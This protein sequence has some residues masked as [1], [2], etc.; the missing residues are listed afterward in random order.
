MKITAFF[1][2]AMLGYGCAAKKMAVSNADTLISYQVTKR[3]PLYTAQK[4]ELGADIDQ[5]LN[6]SKPMAKEIV[7]VI[8]GITL[9]TPEKVD[10]QYR[11][12]E[13]YYRRIASNF[14]KIMSKYM[15]KL[16]YKQQKEFFDTVEL[17]NKGITKKD[18]QERIEDVA[19]RME[20]FL[21]TVTKAQKDIIESY[22][23]YFMDQT[24]KRVERRK[25]LQNRFRNI[26]A[27]DA[28]PEAKQELFQEAFLKYQD[29]GLT[30]NKNQEILK[31]LIPTITKPQRDHFKREAQEIKDIIAYFI[32]T[33][34]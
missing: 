20:T 16:D 31:E 9:E 10:E 4:D 24:T 25:T 34:Y 7:P 23:D 17:E 30:S 1:L 21:G 12:L 32:Q 28:S 8:D 26:F 6:K 2:I 22:G 11:K 3:I 29:E 15:A 5:F 18:K 27:Q 13:T 14:S 19:D 33:N